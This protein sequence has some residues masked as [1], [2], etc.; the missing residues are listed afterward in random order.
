LV[1]KQRTF[2]KW[3]IEFVFLTNYVVC[4]VEVKQEGRPLVTYD[5]CLWPIY[6][7]LTDLESKFMLCHEEIKEKSINVVHI[8]F[9][10][11]CS[12]Q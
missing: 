7:Q 11:Y 4:Y 1:M 9:Y 2:M 10:A 8:L 3:F 5:N 6:L 12:L